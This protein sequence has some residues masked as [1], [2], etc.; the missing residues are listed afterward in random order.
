MDRQ[1]QRAGSRG[2]GHRE[3]G[4]VSIIV[5]LSLVVL[6]G[7]VGLALD[8]GKLY[9]TKSELQ[10]SADA[11]ALSAAR[12][13][14]G[15]ID[16]RIPE[17]D[18]ITAA[19]LNYAYFQGSAVQSLTD[20]NVTFST[21]LSNA[22]QPRSAI[23]AATSANI[24]YVQCT[25]AS[26]GIANWFIQVLNVLPG[27]NVALAQDV[28][29]RAV[30]TVGAAQ[31][32]CALPVFICKPGTETS[33]P[34]AGAAYNIGDWITSKAGSPPT[35]GAGSFGWASLNS[36][37]SAS[38]IASQLTGNQCTLPAAGA[39][40]GSPG[41]KVSDTFAWNTRFGIYGGKYKGPSDGVPDFT[42]YAYTLTTFTAQKNAYPDFV[43]KRATFTSYQGDG[44]PSPPKS[45][46]NT[47][48]TATQ[49]NYY[50][51]ADRRLALAPEVD[52]TQYLTAKQASVLDWVCV[53]MLDPMEK[54][55]GA[56][57]VHLEYRG[58][59]TDPGSPCATQGVP[60]DV[61]AVGPQVPVLVQ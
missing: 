51:G 50:S 24:K 8:L 43:A 17:A 26:T 48:G 53:L 1:I 33:P 13:L 49:S 40:L 30:A 60:G 31:T 5:A 9:V 27:V 14:T 45:G 20:T 39:L 41:N 21:S 46:L 56:G 52:C 3:R 59:S 7:F 57:P 18:G 23:N 29:A 32:T 61:N 2:A 44:T 28:S 11:C 38:S 55:G 22:F 25:A 10:N 12:D 19:H 6:I 4:M 42:G 47:G 35:Y 36:D 34:V 58:R 54:G 16:L 15:A 37:K